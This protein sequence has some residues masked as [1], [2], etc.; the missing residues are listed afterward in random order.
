MADLRRRSPEPP[1]GMPRVEFKPGLAD[2]TLRE[3]APLLAQ[4]GIDV[5]KLEVA[6]LPTLQRALNRAVERR[7]LE[8]F[9][10][11]GAT[12]EIAVL[13]LRRVVEA[14]LTDDTRLAGQLLDQVQPES[15]DNTVATVASCIGIVLGLL[16]DW[17]GAPSGGPGFGTHIPLP[18]G[19]WNGERAAT[20]ML[21][22]ARKGKAF[23]SLDKLLVRHRGPQV[24]A[25][26]ALA[27]A[28]A[29]TTHPQRGDT[30]TRD[31]LKSLIR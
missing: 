15:P 7:N 18:A 19:H 2:E 27:L 29:V 25:G 9:S 12:R 6:D 4:E 10:P 11:M 30:H 16:D 28:A 13:H 23:R 20:D 26:S 14:I 1:A 3:L 17:L 21:A 5:D 22:L 24:L 8:L 31:L